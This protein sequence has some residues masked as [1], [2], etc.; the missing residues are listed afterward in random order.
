MS[1]YT[2]HSY[3]EG[4]KAGTIKPE[5]VLDDYLKKAHGDS[6][7][8]YLRVTDD[9]AKDHLAQFLGRDLHA[10]PIAIKDLILTKWIVT[11]CGSKMLEDFVAPYSATC[12]I[13][14][15]NAWW[16]MIAKANLDEFAMG[17][18]NENSAFGPV[19]NPLDPTRVAGWSSG[20][21][22]AA[23]AGDLAIAALGTDTGWS[24]RM[25]ASL[26]GIV[27][28]KP[29][30]GRVSRYGVQSL[31]SS[32]DQVWTL[33]KTVEDAVT[34]LDAISGYDSNDS[35]SIDRNDRDILFGAL[36]KNDLKGIKLA[37]PKQFIG[38][39]LDAE[40]KKVCLAAI[41]QM[42]S[43]GA[44][45][46]EVD[47]PSLERWVP[48]YYIILPA[49][50]STNLAKFDGIKFGYQEDTMKFDSIQEYYEHI[51]DVWFGDE[52]KRRILI[53]TY[54]L[55]AWFYDAY[56]RRAQQVRQK[57]KM[58]LD[59]IYAKYDAI[60]WPTSPTVAWKI[61]AKVND[62]IAMYLA[63]IYTVIA[64]LAWL[65]AISLPVGF[66]KDEGVSMPVG[67][68]IMCQQWEESKMFHIANCLEKTLQIGSA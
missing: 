24:V 15:E 5:A 23:V 47:I 65:P 35:T 68:Q 19:K 40:V 36:K 34:L 14:L 55:S 46:D 2:L 4:V 53:G 51:R 9:Y 11:T 57:M 49:E 21:S 17:S 67:L 29:T 52:V 1:W 39:G 12:I 31:A 54:V 8:A 64:N 26:C 32:L 61:G 59:A 45:V 37:L 25:P 3:I 13:N 7:N 44:T 6:Y 16:L 28:T 60:V 30:Y 27:W 56:Y 42:K 33:T 18:T 50:A 43:L 20:W 10:A 63:D 66:A 41:E 22:A 38:D 48:T 58:Q 62:P